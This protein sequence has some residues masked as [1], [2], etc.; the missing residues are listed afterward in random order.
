MQT[1]SGS[2]AQCTSEE[3]HSYY[4][5]DVFILK[6]ATK[7]VALAVNQPHGPTARSVLSDRG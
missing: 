5:D 4:L 2:D 1:T 7:A 6:K 3:G